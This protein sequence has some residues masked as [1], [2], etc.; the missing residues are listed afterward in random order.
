MAPLIRPMRMSDFQA[1]EEIQRLN[2]SASQW[3]AA[4]YLAYHTQVAEAQ[5]RVAGFLAALELPEGEAEIL[6]VAVHP[7]FKRQGIAT[8][9]LET[10]TARILYLDVRVSNAAAQ[11]FYRRHG[12]VKSGH[13]RRYYAHPVEDAVMMRRE[14]NH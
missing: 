9:L 13:R 2:P 8:A 14:R 11:A 10:L 12:F 5:G 7:D 6:N 1:I 4:D 3:N